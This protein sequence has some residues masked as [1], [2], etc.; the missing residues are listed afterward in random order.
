MNAEWISTTEDRS[1]EILEV[2]SRLREATLFSRLAALREIALA[3]LEEVD[4]LR[5][6]A[7]NKLSLD[8]EV[9]RF[10]MDLIRAALQKAHGNQALAARMLNVKHTT[11][12]AKIRRYKIPCSA[13]E[14]TPADSATV[15][16]EIAA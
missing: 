3:V 13:F 16:R 2:S 4:S 1:L 10:E 7:A 12:N 9:K 11:L 6:P 5:R 15:S 14:S 8:D